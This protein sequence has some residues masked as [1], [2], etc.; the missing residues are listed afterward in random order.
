M[1]ILIKHAKQ[2]I[3]PKRIKC[4]VGCDYMYNA[5]DLENDA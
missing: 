2:E 3:D 4:F 1:Q 5:A